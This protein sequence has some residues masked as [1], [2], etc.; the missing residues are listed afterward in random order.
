MFAPSW[1]F[2][3][4]FLGLS[5]VVVVAG[6]VSLQGQSLPPLLPSKVLKGHTDP[7]Y[8]VAVSPDG[9]LI[10]TGSFDKSI[11]LWDATT[12]Q[13]LRTLSGKGGHQNQILTVAFSPNNN[14]IASGGSDNVVKVWERSAFKAVGAKKDEPPKPGPS[15]HTALIGVG[16][17]TVV[18]QWKFWADEPT[19]SLAHPNLVDSVAFDN[20]GN[21]L[22][23]GCHD[24]ILRVWD[25][26]KGQATK[27]INAHTLPQPNPIY[28]V[29]WS[30]DFKQILTASF[31]KSI[32]VWDATSGS[33]VR[34]FRP[35]ADKAPV[36]P[37]ISK[38]APA[39]IG[40]V[41]AAWLNAPPERGHRDQVFTLAFHKD[42][43]LLA[44]GSSDR[45]VKLW[46][47][48]SGELVREFPNPNLSAPV[49]GQT[50]FSHPGF[51]HAVKFTPDG[52]KLVSVGT[53][54]RNQGY[55]A[56][57]NVTDGKLLLAQELVIG[58]IYSLDITANALILGCGAKV[59]LQ[60]ESEAVVIPFPGK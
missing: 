6:F 57:W 47:F 39:L 55:V 48:A 40:S 21:L 23:T 5:G 36:K 54:P 34:E 19:K 45:T 18:Q 29:A 50:A 52:T 56:V 9:K 46:D 37:E 8:A 10:A 24:G 32:K 26:T 12:G 41:G 2:V 49:P 27:T 33:L 13:E 20:T 31:D 15:V 58:P 59:R 35:G 17:D 28:C 7:I 4:C 25:V 11:K 38:L 43:K 14:L 51:V 42:G 30:P 3:R 16:L 44:S 53:A 1:H 22:A 60:S